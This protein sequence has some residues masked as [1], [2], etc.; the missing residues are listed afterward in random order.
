MSSVNA[1]NDV[2]PRTQRAWD[3]RASFR[4]AEGDESP[5]GQLVKLPEGAPCP[6][7]RACCRRRR[8]RSSSDWIRTENGGWAR[9]QV[10]QTRGLNRKHDSKVDR[11]SNPPSP[12]SAS[13]HG[14]RSEATEH[15]FSDV[16]RAQGDWIGLGHEA[17][18]VAARDDLSTSA[19][20]RVRSGQGPPSP[21]TPGWTRRKSG[22]VP[23]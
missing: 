5:R 11:T 23:R 20:L 12:R 7:R 22:R 8:M 2:S 17:C 4:Q 15:P 16:G 3:G 13:S 21:V 10:Q 9:G 1:W 19:T 6:H 18:G 14:R